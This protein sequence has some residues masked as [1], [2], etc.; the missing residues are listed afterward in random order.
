SPAVAW[1]MAAVAGFSDA[2]RGRGLP[3]SEHSALLGLCSDNSELRRQL[4]HLFDQ[5]GRMAVDSTE[6]L[7]SRLAAIS[8]LGQADY[9]AA[10]H[11][12]EALLDPQQPSEIQSA[13]IRAVGQLAAP[14]AGPALVTRARWNAYT[15]AVRDA[16]LSA[17]VG[18]TNL[19]QS[20]FSAIEA[21]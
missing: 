11:P 6:P 2:L 21:G 16:A 8:L 9:A 12:L 20:L 7:N 14:E 15:P 13:A 19:L 3:T 4:E 17:L 18:N 1:Q 5:S 10:G